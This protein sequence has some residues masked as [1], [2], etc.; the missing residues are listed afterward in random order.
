MKRLLSYHEILP[1]RVLVRVSWLTQTKGYI[2]EYITV[3]WVHTSTWLFWQFFQQ[4][5]LLTRELVTTVAAI[6]DDFE[7]RLK[8]LTEEG[9]EFYRVAIK[10]WD[11]KVN[12]VIPSG[13]RLPDESDLSAL[14]KALKKFRDSGVLQ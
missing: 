8:D 11:R 12:K 14:E 13:R 5:Q 1:D 3:E 9:F 6:N 4:H 2:N 10:T 7:V